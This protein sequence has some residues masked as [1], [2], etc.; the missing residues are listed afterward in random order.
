MELF[1]SRLSQTITLGGTLPRAAVA[2]LF[3]AAANDGVGYE[4]GDPGSLGATAAEFAEGFDDGKPLVLV[5]DETDG[6]GFHHLQEQ[7]EQLGLTYVV[8]IEAADGFTADRISW[9]HGMAE[10][11]RVR[12]LDHGT[13]AVAVHAVRRALTIGGDA[14]SRLAAVTALLDRLTPIAVPPLVVSEDPAG[15]ALAA[16]AVA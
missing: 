9:H 16:E 13:P 12:V 4:W 8:H 11:D 6:T 14:E 1:V 3:A 5:S 7:C 2:A 15:A 10:P